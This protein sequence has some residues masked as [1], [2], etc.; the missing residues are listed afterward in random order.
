MYMAR[1]RKSRRYQLEHTVCVH[2][3]LLEPLGPPLH[4]PGAASPPLLWP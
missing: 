1:S 3:C 4:L 2:V